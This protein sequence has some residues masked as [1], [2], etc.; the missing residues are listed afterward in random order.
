MPDMNDDVKKFSDARANFILFDDQKEYVDLMTD[1]QAGQLI[2]AIYAHN[3]GET[4]TFSDPLVQMAFLMFWKS[5]EQSR[6]KRDKLRENANKGGRPKSNPEPENNQD[7]T[8]PKP[9]Q[10]QN[11]TK[12]KPND[13]QNDSKQNH[14]LDLS[15]GFGLNLGVESLNSP[16]SPKGDLPPTG[17]EQPAKKPKGKKS[18]FTPPSP[19]EVQDYCDKRNNGI[20]GERFCDYYSAQGWLLSNGQPMQDWQSAV[21]N[22]EYNNENN[23][24]RPSASHVPRQGYLTE[25]ERRQ[26]HNDEVCRRVSAELDAMNSPF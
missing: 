4:V 25:A 6:A 12:D 2:K 11:K 17:G 10:N 18:K 21:R 26:Q 9:N 3:R 15:L 13:N 23:P 20:S 19:Q 8:K 5:I 14:N 22:W 24:S 16:Q 7:E 1:Q